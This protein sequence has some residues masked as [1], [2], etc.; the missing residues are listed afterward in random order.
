MDAA[1]NCAKL[2]SNRSM[3]NQRPQGSRVK[4]K[5]SVNQI[6]R[7]SYRKFTKDAHLRRA[8]NVFIP[9]RRVATAPKAGEGAF[10]KVAG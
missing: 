5:M 3:E 9:L 1:W 10:L 4:K 7:A 2:K 8:M 6:L